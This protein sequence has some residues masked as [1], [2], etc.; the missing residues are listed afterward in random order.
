MQDA[1]ESSLASAW[2]PTQKEVKKA[3][4]KNI[5]LSGTRETETETETET[6][7]PSI[8]TVAIGI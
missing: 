4:F 6:G 2:Q 8:P 3:E 5:R 1:M 7:N